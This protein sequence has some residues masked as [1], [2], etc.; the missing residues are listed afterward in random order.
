MREDEHLAIEVEREGIQHVTKDAN[1]HT[2]FQFHVKEARIALRLIRQW[3]QK[4]ATE[5]FAE[6]TFG[7]E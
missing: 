6:K 4:I 7:R 2:C 3:D 1:N 5:C